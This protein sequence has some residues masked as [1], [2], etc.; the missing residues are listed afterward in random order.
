ME[1]APRLKTQHKSQQHRD[2]FFLV[3]YCEGN[4]FVG[5]STRLFLVCVT[6]IM[7]CCIGNDLLAFVLLL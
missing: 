4:W 1:A 7:I 2:S 3:V 5:L 6:G